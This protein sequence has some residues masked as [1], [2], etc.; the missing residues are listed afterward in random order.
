M[1]ETM[2]RDHRLLHALFGAALIAAVAPGAPLLAQGLES[3][4]AIDKIVGSEVVKEEKQASAE[5]ER[6][7]SAIENTASNT[8]EVRRKFS[9]DRIDIVFLPDA[10]D[11]QAP[12]EIDAKLAEH[13][14]EIADLRREIEGNAMLYHAIDSRSV[15]M[16]DVLA[17]EFDADNGV[18]IFAAAKP[19]E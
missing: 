18:T 4:E 12:S 15:M 13:E 9:L 17:V 3:E 1:L 11:D 5:P 19:V 7:V 6:I 10:A 8:R 14:D 16:S 2:D